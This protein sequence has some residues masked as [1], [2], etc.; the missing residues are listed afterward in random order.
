MSESELEAFQ[1]Q[2]HEVR[3]A[4]PEVLQRLAYARDDEDSVQLFKDVAQG[5]HR[6]RSD[7]LKLAAR[8]DELKPALDKLRNV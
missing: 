1:A 5:L 4:L 2:I 8:Y 6:W 3:A 7:S